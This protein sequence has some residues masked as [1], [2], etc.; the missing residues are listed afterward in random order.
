MTKETKSPFELRMDMLAMAKEILEK[1]FE[2]NKEFAM[3]SWEL[4]VDTANK[5][6][7]SMP[8]M[9]AVPK[10]PTYDEIVELAKKMNSFV[11]GPLTK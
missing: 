5:A 3:K 4:A 1:Q 8:A 9:P 10:Y 2:I 6:K 11:S 7:E